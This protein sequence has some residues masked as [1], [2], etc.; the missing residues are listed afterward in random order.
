MYWL[1]VTGTVRKSAARFEKLRNEK[2]C[3]WDEWV[4]ADAAL[5][6]H[7]VVLQWLHEHHCPFLHEHLMSMYLRLTGVPGLDT[8]HSCKAQVARAK[9]RILQS[10]EDAPSRL[11]L[12]AVEAFTHR[13]ALIVHMPFPR[14]NVSS[15]IDL[16]FHPKT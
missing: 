10:I 4:C 2:D 13:A 11:Y 5:K 8:I 16:S 15:I 9:K 1:P 7:F 12:T 3:P 14:S 6:G